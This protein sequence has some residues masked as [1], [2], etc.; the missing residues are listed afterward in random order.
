MN[1]FWKRSVTYALVLAVTNVTLTP[2]TGA[3]L[4]S[5]EQVAEASTSTERARISALLARPE[6]QAELIRRGV[7]PGSAAERVSA[8]TDEEVRALA[9]RLDQPAAGAS[10]VLGA[11]L[12]VFIVLLVT[13]I[14][15]F[16]KVFSFTRSVK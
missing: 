15:G 13:D 16:T 4:I 8:L 5:T 10:D 12:V 7:S 11:L 6:I 14:L 2:S 9:G 1:R 3:T